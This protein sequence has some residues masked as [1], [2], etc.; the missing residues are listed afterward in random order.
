MKTYIENGTVIAWQDGAHRVMERGVVVV[1]EGDSIVAV[2][3]DVPPPGDGDT[4][5][6]ASGRIVM[7]GF[8]NTHLHVTDTLYTKG[9]LEEASNLSSQARETNYGA[10]Y[11]T[12]PAVRHA[13]DPEAQV[14]AAECAFAE[15]ARTGSTTVVELGYDYEVGGDG[16][17]SITE[18]VAQVAMATGLRCY[19][20]PRYRAMHY[21]HAPG[22]KVWYEK[23][24]DEGRRRFRD[25]V[26]YCIGWD[27]RY[28]GRLRTM[29]APGQIDTCD[30]EMLRETRRVA[31]AHKLPV[32]VHA[33]QSPNEYERI[34]SEY[35]MSTVEYMLDTGLLGPDCL[36]GHGQI[37]TRDGDMA[38]L[39]PSEVAALRDSRTT[40]V[41]LPWVKARRGGVINSI[42]KYRQLGIRQS[43]GTDTYPF[44]MFNDM[45][46][47]ATVCRIVEHSVD[48]ASSADVF[49]MATA[50]GADALGRPDLGRLAAGCKADLVLVR[51]DTFKAAPS[52]DPFKFLVLCATGDDVD[53]VIVAGRTIVENGRVLA[54]DMPAAVARL[55]EAA[56]RV[57]SNIVD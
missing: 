8:V 23:Y 27:S 16:D 10:L 29:L 30:P 4:R 36:I 20:G 46:M 43:L 33:G 14:I 40:V 31:N 52:Y 11:K 19:S 24:S 48:G 17:I 53:R 41:H 34:Q 44:D 13:I 26:D 18:R 25:C 12:L 57:R 45:R 39:K 1:I 51:A 6:D 28:E 37:M 54:V 15:L 55:N 32:Q 21:G 22:G 47:A 9:Y 50:G 42:R 35:G 2:G 38:S 49:T 5:I 56:R 7:P 3:V